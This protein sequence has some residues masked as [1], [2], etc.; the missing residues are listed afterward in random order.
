[1][2][3]K[4]SERLELLNLPLGRNRIWYLVPL[5]LAIVVVA[6]LEAYSNTSHEPVPTNVKAYSTQY[7][8]IPLGSTVYR[9]S[10]EMFWL[11]ATSLKSPFLVVGKVLGIANESASSGCPACVVTTNFLFHI[12]SSLKGSLP[13][14]SDILLAQM[15][16]VVEYSSAMYVN[17]SAEDFPLLRI[18]STYVL[19]LGGPSTV[20]DGTLGRFDGVH[21]Y[22]STSPDGVFTLSP[23]GL[24]YSFNHVPGGVSDWNVDG[25][26]LDS[27]LQLWNSGM[28]LSTQSTTVTMISTISQ[29]T[30]TTWTA[31]RTSSTG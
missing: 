25:M 20:T 10:G 18:G 21:S 29:V 13:S 23:S 17:Y 4:N 27:F 7:P 9:E 19:A 6:S 24:V 2:F 30:S 1:M 22:Y 14:G 3:C 8:Q 12:D 28:N 5:V 31:S 16:G 26:S 11:I 15:G